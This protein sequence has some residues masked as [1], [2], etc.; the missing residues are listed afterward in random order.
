MSHKVRRKGNGVS[1][2]RHV[3]PVM[4]R[5]IA[6]TLQRRWERSLKEHQKMI[7]QKSPSGS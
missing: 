4:R 2:Y 6:K 5:R 3:I 1:T 7:S